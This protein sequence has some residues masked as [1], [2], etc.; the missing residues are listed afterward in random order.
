MNT[1]T[2]W[3][4]SN[5]F[6]ILLVAVGASAFAV[7]FLEQRKIKKVAATIIIEQ[8]NSIEKTVSLLKD[9]RAFGNIALYCS[10][11]IID[12]NV[13]EQ[14]RHLFV[15]KLSSAEYDCIQNFFESAEQ[16][17]HAR[18]DIISMLTNA[19]TNKSYFLHNAASAYVKDGKS[20]SMSAKQ[21][22]QEVQSFSDVYSPLD[23][24][25]VPDI[26]INAILRRLKNFR[27]LSGTT[28][29][30]KIHKMSYNK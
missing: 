16:I 3:I 25:F 10:N 9:D 26:V 24:V 22:E 8:I 11:K 28:A 29:Y 14:Y 1:V 19:W 20:N 23:L 15:K 18:M 4:L 21:I 17:E 6:N 2:A 5:I 27:F 7:Y 13:W 30:K 12:Q